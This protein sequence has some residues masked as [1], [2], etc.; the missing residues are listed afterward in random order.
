MHETHKILNV[1]EQCIFTIKYMAASASHPEKPWPLAWARSASASLPEI[2]VDA[3]EPAAAQQ[4]CRSATGTDRRR[5][6][7]K[8]SAASP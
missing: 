2:A 4:P 1:F 7:T 5:N 6:E 3:S 8:Q